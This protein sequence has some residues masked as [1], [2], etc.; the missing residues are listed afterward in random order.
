LAMSDVT[1]QP[2]DA[3]ELQ[4][5]AIERMGGVDDGHEAFA[6]LSD[7]R[8]I[9]LGVVFQYRADPARESSGPRERTDRSPGRRSASF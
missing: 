3:R 9:T 2:S 7:K 8:G 5:F 1:G 6:C 4:R